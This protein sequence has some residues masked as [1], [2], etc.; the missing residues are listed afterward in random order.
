LALVI[1]LVPSETHVDKAVWQTDVDVP[2][3]ISLH[4]INLHLAVVLV[5]EMASQ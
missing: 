4:V 3:A 2:L 1:Q 5:A